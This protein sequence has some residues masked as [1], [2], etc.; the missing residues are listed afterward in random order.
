MEMS[1]VM[2]SFVLV[3]LAF[4]LVTVAASAYE[5]PLMPAL[6]PVV[7]SQSSQAPGSMSQLIGVYFGDQV[8]WRP[9]LQRHEQRA[10]HTRHRF[11][12][13]YRPRPNLQSTDT[14][15]KDVDL[16][17]GSNPGHDLEGQQFYLRGN[18]PASPLVSN[19]ET[20]V[21]VATRQHIPVELV[22]Q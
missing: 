17:M 9:F 7:E 2:R 20:V 16:E 5:L 12:R 21:E 22:S 4:C 10:Y 15:G 14:I 8:R 13:A 19:P 1:L 11:V 3:T 6:D 18:L